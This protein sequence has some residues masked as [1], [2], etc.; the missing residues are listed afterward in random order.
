M[1]WTFE[2]DSNFT[3]FFFPIEKEK[4]FFK[5]IVENFLTNL[6]PVGN[7]WIPLIMQRQE[8]KKHADFFSIEDT[9]C[10]AMSEKAVQYLKDLINEK[11]ELL[12]IETD[13]GKYYVL[14]IMNV[15]NCLNKE[16]S[17]YTALPNGLIVNYSLLEFDE[18]KLG[19]NAIF[20]ISELPYTNFITDSIQEICE[21]EDLHGLLFDIKS[22]LIWYPE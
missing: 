22:N 20:K 3:Q 17:D 2:I 1:I 11:I 4:I 21:L 18:V 7:N 19:N 16:E 15:I 12:P 5:N 13:A 8:P 9:D 10:I 6:H 14:N